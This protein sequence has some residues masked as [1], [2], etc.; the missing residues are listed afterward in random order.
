M[1]ENNEDYN[2]TP[3]A[4]HFPPLRKQKIC[5]HPQLQ[6]K[7]SSSKPSIFLF[8]KK[9]TVQLME[10]SRYVRRQLGCLQSFVHWLNQGPRALFISFTAATWICPGTEVIGSMVIGSMGYFTYLYVGYLLGL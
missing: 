9:K 5:C 3:E 10:G 1:V 4:Y 7:T 6:K 8:E 2:Y